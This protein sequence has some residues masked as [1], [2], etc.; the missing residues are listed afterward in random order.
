MKKNLGML[1]GRATMCASMSVQ[2][3]QRFENNS[4]MNIPK[5]TYKNKKKRK[6]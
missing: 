4:K 2:S 5:T 6:K 1:I 3:D